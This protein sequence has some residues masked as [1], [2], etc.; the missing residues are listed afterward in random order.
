MSKKTGGIK[1]DVHRSV[2]YGIRKKTGI[3]AINSMLVGPLD[4]AHN[5]C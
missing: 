3:I 1:H 5:K 2:V 4:N